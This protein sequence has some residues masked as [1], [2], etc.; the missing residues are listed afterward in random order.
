MSDV[1]T[2]RALRGIYFSLVLLVLGLAG[3]S[4]LLIAPS[5]WLLYPQI[6]NVTGNE[7]TI[8]RTVLFPIT[9]DWTSDIEDEN[10]LTICWDSG[11]A[12]Y[13]SRGH[14]PESF[15]ITHHGSPCSIP[16]GDY[17]ARISWSPRLGFISLR[18]THRVYPFTVEETHDQP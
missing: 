6:I 13:E 17:L 16:P 8:D 4:V 11:T 14:N 2:I 10:G 7:V 12:H 5:G 18:P 15:S 9:A 3:S 1:K